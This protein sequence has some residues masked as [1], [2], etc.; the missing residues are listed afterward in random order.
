[1]TATIRALCL[2]RSSMQVSNATLFRSCELIQADLDCNSGTAIGAGFLAVMT[3]LA[4][5]K[6]RMSCSTRGVRSTVGAAG[7]A[8]GSP[9]ASRSSSRRSSLAFLTYSST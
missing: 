2:Q 7:T 5:A 3:S 1:M 4:V 6:L 9:A 8:T